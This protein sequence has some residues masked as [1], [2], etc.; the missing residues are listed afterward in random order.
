MLDGGRRERTL[1]NQSDPKLKIGFTLRT[2]E[3]VTEC[4][5]TREEEKKRSETPQLKCIIMYL[6]LTNQCIS[7]LDTI[8]VA[9]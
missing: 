6:I 3:V 7:T 2:W 4:N 1:L 5:N 8:A 9:P